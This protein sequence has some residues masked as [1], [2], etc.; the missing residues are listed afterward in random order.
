MVNSGLNHVEP[1][2]PFF[3]IIKGMV[4]GSAK[5]LVPG[6]LAAAAVVVVVVRLVESDKVTAVYALYED[7]GTTAFILEI[8]VSKLIQV[9]MKTRTI[10]TTGTTKTDDNFMMPLFCLCVRKYKEKQIYGRKRNKVSL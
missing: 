3:K 4:S 2:R 9:M 6:V 5:D 8:E 7:A 10:T 1:L